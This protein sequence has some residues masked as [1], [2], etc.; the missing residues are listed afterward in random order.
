MHWI[1]KFQLFLFDF[2]GL[3]VN[4]EELHFAAYQ[5]MCFDRGFELK[6]DFKRFCQAAHLSARGLCDGIYAEF[7]ALLAQEPRWEVLYQEKKMA[8][9]ELLHGGKLRLL[10]GVAELLEA[11]QKAGIKRCVVT[12]STKEQVE[13]IKMSLPLLKS[14][15]EWITREQYDKPKP[16]PD[17]YLKALERFARPGDLVIGFE[18][19][20]KGLSSLEAAGCPGVLICPAFH[21]QMQTVQGKG[22][23]HF[24]SFRQ[25]PADTWIFN[26][27][28]K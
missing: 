7:P 19:S 4:T 1:H 26:A 23:L 21:P 16:A 3:L 22:I 8:Y 18:D 28:E 17:G 11:L 5:K 27:D 2:D 20:L 15:P 14:I 6:W 9:M 25:I 10:S 24:D 12:N 13:C